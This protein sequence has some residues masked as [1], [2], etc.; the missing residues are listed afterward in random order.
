MLTSHSIPRPVAHAAQSTGQQSTI[1]GLHRLHTAGMEGISEQPS[2]S[3]Q[4]KSSGAAA[5]RRQSIRCKAARLTLAV[6]AVSL[7]CYGRRYAQWLKATAA[8]SSST[9]SAGRCALY[10]VSARVCSSHCDKVYTL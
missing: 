10:V 5:S 9:A 6:S 4:A 1:L 7:F 2:E 3:K 8:G